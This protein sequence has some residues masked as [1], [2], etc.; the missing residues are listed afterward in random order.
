VWAFNLII[1]KY[2]MRTI[3]LGGIAQKQALRK[4][5]VNGSCYR[6]ITDKYCG[7]EVQIRKR[8]LFWGWWS[9][10]IKQINCNTFS[11]IDDAK[12]WIDAG[13]PKEKPFSVVWTSSNGG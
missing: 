12:K 3:A 10:C 7:Y 5:D 4:T 8:F 1:K 9:E 2:K 6:I 13:C 11:T